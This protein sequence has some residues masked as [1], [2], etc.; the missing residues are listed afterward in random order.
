MNLIYEGEKTKKKRINRP[1]GRISTT[2]D[3]N[4]SFLL[5]GTLFKLNIYT[6]AGFQRRANVLL[7]INFKY[8]KYNR[9]IHF[10]VI[11]TERCEMVFQEYVQQI[12][13]LLN[14]F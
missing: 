3:G 4:Y 11:G 8:W 7:N 9:N 5:L 14:H 13:K 12:E 2:R 6:N 1:L 10:Y